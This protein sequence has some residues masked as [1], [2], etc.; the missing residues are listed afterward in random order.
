MRLSTRHSIALIVF[1]AWG[2]A[3]LTALT[4]LW[5][6]AEQRAYICTCP[7]YTPLTCRPQRQLPASLSPKF[8]SVIYNSTLSVFSSF[9]HSSLVISALLQTENYIFISALYN[10]QSIIW[11]SLSNYT[12]YQTDELGM[13]LEKNLQQAFCFHTITYYS[14]HVQWKWIRTA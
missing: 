9:R 1:G 12:T 4:M 5:F 13:Q 3:G 2:R 6:L 11:R 10:V 7:D 8:L 14:F